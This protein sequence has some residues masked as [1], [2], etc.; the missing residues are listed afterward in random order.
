MARLERKIAVVSGAA[1][2]IGFA[3]AQAFANEGA[4]VYLLDRARDRLEAA[5]QALPGEGHQAVVMD[6]TDEAAW[7]ALAARI[8][9]D[10]GRLDVLVNNAGF[11]DFAP[12]VETTLESWRS[13]LAVNLDSVFLATKHMM[14]LLAI[15]G[16]GSI[17]NMSSIRALRGGVNMASYSAAKAGVRSLT[18]VTAVECAAQ[19]NG[20]R[21][22]SVH[23]GH[24]AT[25]LTAGFHEDPEMS[26]AIVRNIPAGRVGAP[27]DI[28]N[29]IVFLASDESAFMTGAQIV[30]DG[31]QTV[32]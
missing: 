12:I 20:V 19:R 29:A 22:N 23:P 8:T 25:P 18:Q 2:G 21:A 31:G 13:I 10:H 9:H 24:I 4:R 30:V 6:V 32:K 1:S 16:S 5:V 28:A 14:P 26:A 11:G 15:S 17:I 3:T 27:A 7:A